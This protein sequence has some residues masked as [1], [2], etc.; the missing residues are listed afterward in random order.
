[1]YG[2]LKYGSHE[3]EQWIYPPEDLVR[4][5]LG[6]Y[7]GDMNSA[8]EHIVLDRIYQKLEEGRVEPL[9]RGGWRDFLRFAHRGFNAPVYAPTKEDVNDANKELMDMFHKGWRRIPLRGLT[10]PEDLNQTVSGK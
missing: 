3:T 8:T 4:E 7:I 9:S 2:Y 6:H 10:I 1:M 5:H